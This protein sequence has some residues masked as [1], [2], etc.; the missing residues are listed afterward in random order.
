MATMKE[1]ALDNDFEFD[2]R[3]SRK[4]TNTGALEPAAGLTGCYFWF[5]ATDAGAE[6]HADVKIAATERSST[7][8]AYYAICDGDDI[9]AKL[10]SYSSV[11]EV[12]G[13]SLNVFT[14]IQRKVVATRKPEEL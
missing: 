12:F 1:I 8:G 10:A 6:I 13:D 7:P 5:S 4:N 3:L 14:S 11:F 9:R 2:M